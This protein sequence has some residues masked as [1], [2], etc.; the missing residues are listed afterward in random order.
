M[1]SHAEATCALERSPRATELFAALAGRASFSVA[2]RASERMKWRMPRPP[3]AGGT[4]AGATTGGRT[5]AA[6][7]EGEGRRE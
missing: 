7:T 2:A 1:H 4:E 5:R 3:R 6:Y